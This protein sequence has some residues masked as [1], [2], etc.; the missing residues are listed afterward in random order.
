MTSTKE[1][2]FPHITIKHKDA[3]DQF[4]YDLLVDQS[5]SYLNTGDYKRM[6]T[7]YGINDP[8]R[9]YPFLSEYAKSTKHSCLLCNWIKY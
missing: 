4:N 1:P 7:H 5:D 3:T 8:D 2:T 9:D 6:V